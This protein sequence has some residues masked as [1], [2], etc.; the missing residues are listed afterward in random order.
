MGRTK[1]KE[2]IK[3]YILHIVNNKNIFFKTWIPYIALLLLNM[4]LFRIGPVGLFVATLMDSVIVLFQYRQIIDRHK[5]LQ[6]IEQINKGDYEAKVDDSR[7]FGE[8]SCLAKEINSIGDGIKSAVEQSMKDEKMKADLITNVSHDLKTPL[9]SIVNYVE[10]MKREE[11]DNPKLQ[12]YLEIL[13]VKSHKLKQLTEDLVEVSKISSGNISVELREINFV[14]LINQTIGEFYDRLEGSGLEVVFKSEEPSMMVKADP[15][16]L[17][18]VIENL[19]GNVCKYAQPG[20]RVYMDMRYEN[21]EYASLKPEK[22]NDRKLSNRYMSNEYL[23]D[24]NERQFDYE[25]YYKFKCRKV[26]YTIRNICDSMMDVDAADLT[27]RFYRGDAS[28]STEGSGLGLAIARN[29]VTL[30]GGSLDV[31]LD[32]AVFKT[33][34]EFECCARC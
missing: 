6:T 16:H 21:D 15:R 5:I 18:R 9:T 19:V 1:E 13:E 7:M 3:T 23:R 10:L 32:G 31:T 11:L 27:E 2:K 14:E 4:L 12:E 34:I 33:E 17:W 29:L 20:T 26:I 30:Q 8:N 22:L 24:V 25:D 28:R